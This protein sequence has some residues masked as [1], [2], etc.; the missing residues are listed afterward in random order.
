[1]SSWAPNYE[2]ANC[3]THVVIAVSSV[4]EERCGFLFHIH[5]EPPNISRERQ[6]MTALLSSH[7]ALS[8]LFS[9]HRFLSG[10]VPH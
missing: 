8:S 4:G 1:M 9:S 6:R 5:C 10:H 7:F 3:R 2:T